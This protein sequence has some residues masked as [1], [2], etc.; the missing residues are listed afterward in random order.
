[1]DPVLEFTKASEFDADMITQS[2]S[3]A[4]ILIV[5]LIL[6]GF[7]KY[8]KEIKEIVVIVSD[9]LLLIVIYNFI[10]KQREYILDNFGYK[11]HF[12]WLLLLVLL[13]LNVKNIYSLI[14]SKSAKKE[15]QGL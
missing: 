12:V 14:K 15:K 7:L 3:I 1:M 13:V 6:L 5:R 11:V 9:L 4:T 8:K 10:F 2:Y